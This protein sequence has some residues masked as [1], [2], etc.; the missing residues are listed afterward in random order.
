[1]QRKNQQTIN[2]E[3]KLYVVSQHE[4]GERTVDICHN[5]KFLHICICTI[6][7]ILKELKKVLSQE[8]KCLCTKT[9]MILLE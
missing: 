6:H 2:I 3:E 1:M 9:A 7:D 4:K 5:V 8:I